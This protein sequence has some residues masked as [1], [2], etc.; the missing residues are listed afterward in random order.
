MQVSDLGQDYGSCRVANLCQMVAVKQAQGRDSGN[1]SP[2][3]VIRDAK[4]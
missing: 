3:N 2:W 1:I 4:R